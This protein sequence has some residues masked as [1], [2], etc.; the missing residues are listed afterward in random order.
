METPPA[1]IRAEKAFRDRMKTLGYKRML[2]WVKP[3]WKPIIKALRKTLEDGDTQLLL[4][5]ETNK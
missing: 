1:Q 5:E 2:L 3:E 4:E